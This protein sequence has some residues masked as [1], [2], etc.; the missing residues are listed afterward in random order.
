FKTFHIPFGN[1]ASFQSSAIRNAVK[2]TFSEGVNITT[3]PT[4]TAI[5]LLAS[6]TM[7]GK[8]NGDTHVTTPNG[9]FFENVLMYPPTLNDYFPVNN[10]GAPIAKSTDSIPRPIS[11]L[12]SDN[13]FPLSF[14]IISANSS[15]FCTN[16]SLNLN[17]VST[18]FFIE[19]VSQFF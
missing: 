4:V 7:I 15:I 1:P 5:T 9:C 11:P 13:V 8:L 16:N 17:N 10:G 6:G 19:T 14:P 2:G 3:L 12:E 18:L